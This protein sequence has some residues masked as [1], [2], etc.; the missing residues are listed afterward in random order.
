MQTIS[1]KEGKYHFG[2]L[3]DMARAEPVLVEKHGRPVVVV[4]G[5]RPAQSG[6]DLRTV[7]LGQ[8][9]EHVSLSLEEGRLSSSLWCCACHLRDR[10]GLLGVAHLS[11]GALFGAHRVGGSCRGDSNP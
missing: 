1:A 7:A 4:L 11:F 9:L 5:P 8:V 6:L 2:R 3:I 10:G